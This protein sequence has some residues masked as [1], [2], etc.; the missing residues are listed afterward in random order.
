MII[1]DHVILDPTGSSASSQQIR[2]A[3]QHQIVSHKTKCN[4]QIRQKPLSLSHTHT[5][6]HTWHDTVQSSLAVTD[7]S[8]TH[9]T[10]HS[11]KATVVNTW[12]W[13]T[14]LTHLCHDT[15]PLSQSA[16]VTARGQ[17]MTAWRCL[18]SSCN[19]NQHP[20]ASY[21]VQMKWY[22]YCHY[23]Q[24]PGASYNVQMK[25][26]RYCQLKPASRCFV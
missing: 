3:R 4:G 22:R 5:H 16:T 26:Y 23:N 8:G 25:W 20:G 6:T 18:T 2:P 1:S 19:Y 10:W 7:M 14:G 17:T 13:F 24:H 12:R 9:L 21:N 11:G 15:M